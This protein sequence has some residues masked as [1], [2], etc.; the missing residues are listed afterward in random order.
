MS[1]NYSVTDL[2]YLMSR[3]RDPETG[4]PWDIKQTYKSITAYTVEEVYEVVDAIDRNDLTHLS[5]ELGD[6]LFQIIFYCQLAEEQGAFDFD[7]V[8]SKITCKL[9]RRHPHV[10][11]EGSLQSTRAGTAIDEQEI[12]R[13]WESIKQQER[14]QK[15]EPGILDDIPLALPALGRAMKL[16]K[17]AAGVG[18]DWSGVGDVISKVREELDELQDEVDNG[19]QASREEELGDLIFTCVNLARHLSIDPER[20]LAL[21]NNKFKRRFEA[22]DSELDLKQNQS[23]AIATLEKAWQNAKKAEN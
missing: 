20:A 2:Q 10:F 6:L 7:Q 1:K 18:F 8:V 21:S 15:G 3:L 16:Q 13:N 5:E 4:C 12:K 17:R 9:V 23:L 11:P 22:V 19:D 14:Q